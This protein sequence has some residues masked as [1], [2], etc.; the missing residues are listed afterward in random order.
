MVH[1]LR[2]MNWE[3]PDVAY[4]WAEEMNARFKEYI[5]KGKYRDLIDYPSLGKG[6]ML[7]IPTPEHYLPMLYVLGLKE[8]N[9]EVK[10]F[11]DRT[12]MGSVSMT[13]FKVQASQ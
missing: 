3:N 6:A 11:N 10:F 5:I 12:V 7:S 8:G 9:E 2:M 4:D 13:S 1:N